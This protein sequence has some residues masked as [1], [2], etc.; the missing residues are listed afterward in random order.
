[1]NRLLRKSLKLFKTIKRTILIKVISLL[2]IILSVGVLGIYTFEQGNKQFDNPIDIL[3]F[4]MTVST[5]GFEDIYLKTTIGK[6]CLLFTMYG[7]LII[8][9]LLSAIVASVLIEYKL[10]DIMGMGQYSFENHIVIIGWNRKGPMIIQSLREDKDFESKP[11]VIISSDEKKPPHIDD[12]NF[13]HSDHFVCSKES[14]LKASADKAKVVVLLA[15]YGQKEG[16]DSTTSVN[17]LMVRT[18]NK[19]CNIVAEMLAPQS[20]E[21]MEAAGASYI[22]GVAEIGGVLIAESCKN[23]SGENLNWSEFLKSN[24]TIQAA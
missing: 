11:I 3:F 20:R 16:S 6:L 2:F 19:D 8:T 5:V 14:L 4:L 21:H 18:L 24:N 9:A 13:I 23:R 15:D 10:K 7:T 17:C 1:M 22:I 12:L